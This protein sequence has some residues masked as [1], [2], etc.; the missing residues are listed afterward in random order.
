MK[1]VGIGLGKTGTTTLGAALQVLGYDHVQRGEQRHLLEA[2]SRGNYEALA[3]VLDRRDSVDD[4]PW[5]LVYQWVA[6]RHPDAKFVLT[7]RKD[8]ETWYQSLCSHV[9]SGE[10]SDA[11][12]RIALGKARPESDPNH[13]LQLYK[14]HEE[15]VRAFFANEPDRLLVV[16][17]ENGDG[18]GKLCAFLDHTEP[19][20]AFPHSNRKQR[21]ALKV[22]KKLDRAC[23]RHLP[24][25]NPIRSIIKRRFWTASGIGSKY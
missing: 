24:L 11:D 21:G 6:R 12:R 18:W 19:K 7:L 23:K 10:G 13:F 8:A 25:Y 3:E 9:A 16:C 15:D 5:P 14:R 1:V 17:W 4:F 22:A 20:R 2:Y